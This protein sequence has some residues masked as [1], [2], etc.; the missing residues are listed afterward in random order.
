MLHGIINR[1]TVDNNVTTVTTK[2]EILIPEDHKLSNFIISSYNDI[3]FC[4]DPTVKKLRLF[5]TYKE[6]AQDHTSAIYNMTNSEEIGN[7]D[8]ILAASFIGSNAK[9]SYV[10]VAATQTGEVK[11]IV[12]KVVSDKTETTD[13]VLSME[14]KTIFK[15]IKFGKRSKFSIIDE[16]STICTSGTIVFYSKNTAKTTKIDLSEFILNNTENGESFF[17]DKINEYNE[18]QSD[19][20]LGKYPIIY[21]TDMSD[22]EKANIHLFI[23]NLTN[24][25]VEYSVYHN[26]NDINNIYENSEEL[27]T[28]SNKKNKFVFANL[29]Y[30]NE[31]SYKLLIEFKVTG[32]DKTDADRYGFYRFNYRSV[33]YDKSETNVAGGENILTSEILI[34]SG[35]SNNESNTLDIAVRSNIPSFHGINNSKYFVRP[36]KTRTVNTIGISDN[37]EISNLRTIDENTDKPFTSYDAESDINEVVGYPLQSKP[38]QILYNSKNT[39]NITPFIPAND[40]DGIIKKNRYD[41]KQFVQSFNSDGVGLFGEYEHVGADSSK[42]FEINTKNTDP[43]CNVPIEIEGYNISKDE[44]IKLSHS[45]FSNMNTNPE[46]LPVSEFNNVIF[47]FINIS[48]RR[49]SNFSIQKGDI[50]SIYPLYNDYIIFSKRIKN[51]SKKYEEYEFGSKKLNDIIDFVY[52]KFR[53]YEANYVSRKQIAT[54]VGDIVTAADSKSVKDKIFVSDG[55]IDNNDIESLFKYINRYEGYK[56]KN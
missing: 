1:F 29:E 28:L 36:S 5:D 42:K 26:H 21:V 52:N 25:S 11:H 4:F 38:A 40:D 7:I 35:I 55:D 14:V 46:I 24:G 15:K 22:L 47:P 37:E 8:R 30:A 49:F 44:F 3:T 12:F 39:D 18:L 43:N 50:D 56:I 34:D 51:N 17:V 54:F 20:K 23:L 32:K 2:D 48:F 31:T 16:T 33:D 53:E 10:F 9:G 13:Y 6:T 45:E 19:Y 41:M 27:R